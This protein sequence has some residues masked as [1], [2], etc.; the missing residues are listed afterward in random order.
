MRKRRALLKNQ[1]HHSRRGIMVVMLV[2]ALGVVA[3][4]IAYKF[5]D[6][7]NY[8][9]SSVMV[10]GNGYRAHLLA[11]SGFQAGLTTLRTVP[12]EYLFT[13]GM[14]LSPP[15]ITMDGCKPRCLITYRIYPEDGKL[16]LNYLVRRGDDEPNE[17]YRAI[18]NRFFA[19]YEIPLSGVDSIIDWI[20]SNNFVTGTGGEANYYSSLNPPQKIKNFQMFSM[21]EVAQVKDINW[22]MIY[23]SRAPDGWLEAQKE[24]SFQTEDEKTL[25]TAPDWIPANNMTAF[26]LG[27]SDIDT[28]VNINA[29][30][31]HV[32]LAL[33]DSMTREVILA[34]F[35]LRRENDTYI[36]NLDL[37]QQIPEF[38]SMTSLGVSLF[39]ELT[40]GGGQTGLIKT[41]GRYYRII[42]VGSI[43]PVNPEKANGGVVRKVMGI[44]D[45]T[46]KA[47][48]YYEED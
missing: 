6:D 21:S 8:R 43:L 5:W 32:L 20:D 45:K 36:K 9:L 41:E 35:K 48:L 4:P 30:R 47:L 24:L 10:N 39:E 13:S 22:D 14:A 28:R 42:G 44:Y 25:L 37:L 29:A 38:Q 46:S 17:E 26:Y 31:Y 2:M 23:A 27:Q 3:N 33:S 40:G 16:N 19:N 7:S 12:E 11:K 1:K 18:F 15:D 34:L